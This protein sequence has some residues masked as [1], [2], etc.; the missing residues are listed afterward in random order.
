M[1]N[2]AFG[3]TRVG[4]G[5]FASSAPQLVGRTWIGEEAD[6]PGAG[7]ILRALGFRDIALGAG[8]LDGALRGEARGWLAVCM[9][10]DLGD[11]ATTLIGRNRIDRQS[12]V[13]TTF[14]AGSAAVAS[15]VLLALNEADRSTPSAE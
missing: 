3:M 14:F 2:V 1:L 5:I 10:S 12:V 4:F 8:T 7:V 9:L 13:M 11:V 6:R 15:G